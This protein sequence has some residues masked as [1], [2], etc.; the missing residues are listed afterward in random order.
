MDIGT[1]VS[2]SRQQASITAQGGGRWRAVTAAAATTAA[3]KEACADLSRAWRMCALTA[4][5]VIKSITAAIHHDGL[6]R[7]RI[8]SI[9]AAIHQDGL[10]LLPR[11]TFG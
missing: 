5:G 10:G 1:Q 11:F 3:G 8:D 4:D 6:G 2:Q 7:I 9:T